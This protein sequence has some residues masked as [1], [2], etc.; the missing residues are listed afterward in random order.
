MGK[1]A[2][3]SK[4]LD[5]LERKLLA[6]SNADSA[7]S[8]NGEMQELVDLV[9]E[10]KETSEEKSVIKPQASGLFKQIFEKA[11]IGIVHYDKSGIIDAC[12][13]MFVDILDSSREDLYGLNI[14]ELKNQHVKQAMM[15]ALKGKTAHYEGLYTSVT[16]GKTLP[17]RVEFHPEYSESGTLIG[18]I[19]MLEDISER[20]QA[21]KQIAESEERY[22]TLFEQN[23]SVMLLIDGDDGSIH[24]AN[25]AALKFYGW[26]RSEMQEMKISDINTLPANEIREEMIKA[27][28]K[29]RNLF[30]FKHRLANGEIRDVEVYSGMIFIDEKHYLYSI[31][32]DITDR[33]QTQKDL[34]QFKLGIENSS[35]MIVITDTDGVI[36]YAN[37]AFRKKY[38]YSLEEIKGNTPRLI[39][40]D[41]YSS[42]FYEDYWETLLN[43]KV[44]KG[45]MVNKTKWGEEV[46]ISYSTNPIV[47]RDGK[48]NGFIAIQDDITEQKKA[49]KKL[50]ESLK[51]KEVLL[52][53][54]HHRVKNNLAIISALLEL[55]LYQSDDEI[56]IDEFVRSSQ[57][58][59]KAIAEVH[60]M[61]YQ[62]E[63]FSQI[64]FKE[65][66]ERLILKIREMVQNNEQEIT[67]ETNLDETELNINQAIPVGLI[68]DELIMN[69]LKYAFNGRQEGRVVV[70]L[71]KNG[72]DIKVTVKDNGDG[73]G[74]E[75]YREG[76]SSLGKT[77]IQILSQQIGGQFEFEQTG[78]GAEYT[79]CFT[80][81]E[82]SG[83]AG[84]LM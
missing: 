70:G 13:E 55:N 27:R 21:A 76:A 72:Q 40:S 84:N 5:K 41:R 26:S 82:M 39:K 20:Y 22:R 19:G 1:L 78:E 73:S 42:Q 14:H 46:H 44:M 60:E 75:S 54:I 9:R 28:Q 6:I 64:S 15:E 77:L 68:I 59:I 45:E 37:P 71:T 52:S 23:E 66:L 47:D 3:I 83:S 32:H 80:Q 53:E 16:S 34:M 51:E 10:L 74:L 11:P 2:Y 12:N 81:G 25:P 48:L 33:V 57:M 17:I 8:L 61:L 56:T 62:S 35:N 49:E 63:H 31:I 30:H 67:F 58:R 69:T 36:D 4:G 38:G 24:D 43:K 79:I 18:G 65:Y 7:D 50:S 29:H